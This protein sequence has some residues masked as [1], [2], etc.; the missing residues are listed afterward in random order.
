MRGRAFCV[1]IVHSEIEGR[2]LA[3]ELWYGACGVSKSVPPAPAPRCTQ[4]TL[5]IV[6]GVK[7]GKKLYGYRYDV[8]EIL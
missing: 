6:T 3:S 1:G 7:S 4:P 8:R 2:V 5:G